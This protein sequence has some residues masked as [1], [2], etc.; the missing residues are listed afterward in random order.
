MIKHLVN[1]SSV[2][3][4]VYLKDGTEFLGKDIPTSPL[5]DQGNMISFWVDANTLRVYP[6]SEV[7]YIEFVEEPE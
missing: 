2:K 5:G 1:E 4:N 3:I 6:L 7:S